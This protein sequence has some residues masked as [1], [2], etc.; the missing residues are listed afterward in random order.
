M[1]FYK[2]R[3]AQLIAQS[4]RDQPKPKRIKRKRG[5]AL[6]ELDVT[7]Q[8]ED[9]V[10][11]FQRFEDFALDF[12]KWAFSKDVY[13]QGF[14]QNIICKHIPEE[15]QGKESHEVGIYEAQKMMF[16]TYEPQ[17]KIIEKT[18]WKKSPIKP[19]NMNEPWL[20][21]KLMKK[22]DRLEELLS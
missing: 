20:V 5:G 14:N 9:G 1:T 18:R 4:K 3:Y 12:K 16:Q 8:M 19:S 10:S 22:I 13:V 11:F 17:V 7:L 21:Q 6:K 2:D 15:W